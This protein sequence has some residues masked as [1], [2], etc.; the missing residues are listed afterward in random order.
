MPNL[1][2]QGKPGTDYNGRFFIVVD[3]AAGLDLGYLARISQLGFS[4]QEAPASAG[5]APE[6]QVFLSSIAQSSK[7]PNRILITILY[8]LISLME[9][10]HSN[11]AERGWHRSHRDRLERC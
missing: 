9:K 1:L 5:L 3:Q 6:D 4:S 2:D 7:I 8:R 10:I 11:R